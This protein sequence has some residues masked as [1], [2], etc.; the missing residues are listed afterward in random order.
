[1]YYFVNMFLPSFKL[2]NKER[3]GSK[4]IKKYEPPRTP[5]EK[6]LE[7]NEIKKDVKNS[8]RIKFKKLNPYKLE[9]E[10]QQKI[11]D[12]FALIGR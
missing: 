11:K 10:I 3:V 9:K 5:L 6:L 12:I 7:S 1:W 4:I 2:I 8:L